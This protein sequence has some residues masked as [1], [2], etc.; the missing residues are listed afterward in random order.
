MTKRK[1][2][3]GRDPGD[4]AVEGFAAFLDDSALIAGVRR[5]L[6][7]VSGGPDSTCLAS[8][9]GELGSLGGSPEVFL[10]HVHHGIRGEEA[11]ADEAFVRELATEL[12]FPLHVER[13][14]V[15]AVAAE[16]GLSFEEAGRRLRYGTF[17][18]WARRLSL[19]AVALAHQ[20]E[21]Q[22]E[23]LLLRLARGTGLRGLRGIPVERP[24]R[25]CGR[26]VRIIRPLLHWSRGEI[27]EFLRQRGRSFR[28]DSSNAGLHCGRNAVRNQILPLLEKHVHP[29]SRESLERLAGLATEL[30]R[31]LDLLVEQAWDES[32]VEAPEG[33]VV[34]SRPVLRR[35]PRTIGRE[36]LVRAASHVAPGRPAFPARAWKQL[37]GLLSENR[38][39]GRL[40]LGGGVRVELRYGLL[41]V[42]S[43]REE[44]LISPPPSES[45]ALP[46]GSDPVRWK[47]WLVGAE[48]LPWRG[49]SNDSLEEWVNGDHLP[50]GLEVR[51]RRPGDTF[52]PLGA[53]GRQKL[54]E[55]LRSRRIPPDARDDLPLVVSGGEI[56]WVVGQRIDHRFRVLPETRNVVRLYARKA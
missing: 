21:D 37:L 38:H 8:L 19:D 54:K 55:F 5:L 49:G 56:I 4:A 43:R 18:Q 39:A 35:W 47:A 13:V 2:K 7:A 46:I 16:K 51:S 32:R 30:G 25:D 17:R 50:A 28:T 9:F 14:S 29:G 36:V 11:D 20:R 53:P 3:A 42:R 45:V 1:Q 33:R 34:L 15:P 22:Q 40:D 44:A 26:P 52:H 41:T 31:D 10:G 6:V 48:Q 27:L 12:G 24:L 23:T